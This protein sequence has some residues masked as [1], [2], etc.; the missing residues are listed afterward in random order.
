M[1]PYIFHLTNCRNGHYNMPKWYS[2]GL[3]T[4]LKEYFLMKTMDRF[5]RIIAFFLLVSFVSCTSAPY[6]IN[7]VS[8]TGGTQ[9]PQLR[10]LQLGG[11]QG[12]SPQTARQAQTTAQPASP[13]WTGDGGKGKSITILPPRSSGLAENQGY[14]PDFI[15]NELV[16]NFNTFSAMT[17]FDRVNNQKQYEELLSGENL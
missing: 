14:L 4:L 3:I 13:Y 7:G 16:S 12:S 5:C 2:F 9:S 1:I 6:T 15:A 11:S 8:I 17:L 10:L